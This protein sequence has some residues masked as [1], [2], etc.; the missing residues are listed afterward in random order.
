MKE[1]EHEKTL[2]EIAYIATSSIACCIYHWV[3]IRNM[4]VLVHGKDA[5]IEL[6]IQDIEDKLM[7]S[8][9]SAFGRHF[10]LELRKGLQD[11]KN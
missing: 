3:E 8:V 7:S 9:P 6:K 5:N 11:I 10:A 2:K 4:D 1:T